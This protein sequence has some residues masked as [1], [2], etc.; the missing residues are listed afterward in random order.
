MLPEDP[1]LARNPASPLSDPDFFGPGSDFAAIKADPANWRT[2]RDLVFRYAVFAHDLELATAHGTDSGVA[3]CLDTPPCNDFIVSL[4]DWPPH[5]LDK[6]YDG[7]S[8][9]GGIPLPGPGPSGLPVHGRSLFHAVTFMHELGHTFGLGHGGFSD[10]NFKPNY[11]SVAN[12]WFFAPGGLIFDFTDDGMLLNEPVGKDYNSD[13]ID[14]RHR[15]MFSNEDLPTLHEIDLNEEL[16]IEDGFAI[17]GHFC[18]NGSVRVQVGNKPIDWNCNEAIDPY[19]AMDPII[20]DVNNDGEVKQLSGWEDYGFIAG[21]G[22][23]FQSPAFGMSLKELR[24]LQSKTRRIVTLKNEQA[25]ADRCESV[26]LI[27]FEEFPRGTVVENQYAPSVSFLKDALRK[28][29]I[30]DQAEQAGL[31]TQSPLNSL[32][33][34]FPTTAAPLVVSFE[35]PQRMVGLYLGWDRPLPPTPDNFA[36][37]KAYDVWDN[38]MGEDR[39][40]LTTGITGFLGIGAIFAHERIK[41]IEIAYGGGAA[42]V[43]VQID[44]LMLCAKKDDS[45][46][47]PVFA[48]P[49]VF[50]DKPVTIKVD[51][52]R[53]GTTAGGDAEPGHNWSFIETP[54]AGIP[55]T[56]NG[57]SGDTNFFVTEPEGETITFKAP[58]TYTLGGEPL[59]F[60]R[61]RFDQNIS[62]G[63]GM[64]EISLPLSHNATLTA[65]YGGRSYSQPIGRVRPEFRM[66]EWLL[67]FE[68]LLKQQSQL[69]QKYGELLDKLMD[70]EGVPRGRITPLVKIY[71]ELLRVNA[72]LLSAYA[73]M[74]RPTREQA[75]A[76]FR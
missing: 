70:L 16:G 44:D 73:A 63:D 17:T 39:H 41:R 69:L 65:V 15:L 29:T 53:I 6:D 46:V 12:D 55:I 47:I 48:Q 43:P 74:A 27:S 31:A 76:S 14:D 1:E 56:A 32:I 30:I 7:F 35:W 36:V 51:S 34:R 72:D 23:D 68:G 13:G 42:D 33:N 20:V 5:N 37:L 9:H 38:P 66:L 28:P 4:G 11:L 67:P 71:G 50:G 21:A 60:L 49:P 18:A 24:D 26:E 75:P 57:A 22:I 59:E 2:A 19:D 58:M 52:A 64:N 61:W 54:V 3:E 40:L 45:A 25:L 8:D 62:F 10:R